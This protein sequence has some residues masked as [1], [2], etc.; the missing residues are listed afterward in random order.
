LTLS[1][2]GVSSSTTITTTNSGTIPAGTS[3]VVPNVGNGTYTVRVASTTQSATAQFTVSPTSS[4]LVGSKF[5]SVNGSAYTTAINAG[6]GNV[7]TYQ[8][9]FTNNTGNSLN[10]VATDVLQPGQTIVTTGLPCTIVGTN[11]LS[12]PVTVPSGSSA[13]VFFSTVVNS[14]FSGPITNQATATSTVTG[15]TTAGPSVTTNATVVNVG[16]SVPAGATFELCGPVTGYVPAGATSNGSITISGVTV[17]IAAGTTASNVVLGTNEC[18]LAGVNGSGQLISVVG[19]TN[20]S[21]V[22]VACGVYT[23]A[24]AG[25]VNAGGIPIVVAPGTTFVGGLTAGAVYCFILNSSGQAIG[26]VAGIPTAAIFP[27]RN[28]NYWIERARP[29]D[30]TM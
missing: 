24:A 26:A 11:T 8:L 5:V 13:S 9:Q 30:L 22:S 25:F 19:T 7:L 27:V 16:T 23:T 1:F 10:V 14:G 17:V 20:L 29:S 21:G 18:I 28:H 6:P 15:T 12:C 3:F 4:S 2:N